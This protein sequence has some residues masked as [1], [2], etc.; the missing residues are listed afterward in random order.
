MDVYPGRWIIVLGYLV[1][2][3]CAALVIFW[4]VTPAFADPY[5]CTPIWG[6][7]QYGDPSRSWIPPGTSCTFHARASGMQIDIV[8]RP[9]AWR[10]IPLL[11]AV[12]GFPLTRHLRRLLRRAAVAPRADA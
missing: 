5:L 3:I 2:A 6:N 4:L 12:T 11:A 7:G 1:T 9:T 10:L 8:N